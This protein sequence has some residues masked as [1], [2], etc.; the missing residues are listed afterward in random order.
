[1]KKIKL[2]VFLAVLGMTALYWGCGSP[3]EP[4]TENTK[5]EDS[6]GSESGVPADWDPVW[7]CP[8][9]VSDNLD[10]TKDNLGLVSDYVIIKFNNGGAPTVKYSEGGGDCEAGN[11]ETID[12]ENVSLSI[13]HCYENNEIVYS[14]ILT[15]KAVNGSVKVDGGHRKTLYLNGVDITNP[16]K[17]AINIQSGKRVDV[18][19]VGSC[20][21]RN[22]L[23]GAGYDVPQGSGAPQAK[24]AFFS[25]GS[26]VFGGSGSLEVRSTRKHAI[27]SDGFIEVNSGNILIYESANDGIHANERITISGGKLQIK[28]VGDAIQNEKKMSGKDPAYVTVSGGDIKIRTTGPK[29]HGIVSD[30]SDVIITGDATKI[31]ITLTGNGSKGIRSHGNVTISGA[32]TYLEAYGARESSLTTD[33]TSSAAGIRADG[34]VEITK[35]ILTIKCVRANENGKGLNVDG[36]LK[37]GGGTTKIT[38]DGDGVRVRGAITMT[39]GVLDTKSANKSDIDCDGKITRTGGTLTADKIKQGS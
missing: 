6:K 30:S 21:R 8:A 36:N 17:P 24:A 29:G 4:D 10:L 5:K 12:G 11:Y 23:K 15:G 7:A 2:A 26:L 34:D 32:N 31:N 9:G 33:D 35:G 14:I 3:T 39:G 25:E 38:A 18:Y 22:I 16:N 13:G 27:V 19:L 37:I 28:C 1:M 20:D